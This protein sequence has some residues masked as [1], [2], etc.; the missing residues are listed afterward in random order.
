MII[1]CM[2]IYI[3][4]YVLLHPV[5]IA[6]IHYPRSAPRAG[7][8][9]KEIRTLSARL[10]SKGRVRKDPNLGL[11]T[12]CIVVCLCYVYCV[13]YIV[14]SLL[15]LYV[16]LYICPRRSGLSHYI[17]DHNSIYIYIYT[18]RIS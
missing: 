18:V 16:L 11:R 15:L 3:Y 8:G 2:Y 6:R 12:G 9:F 10:I 4:I 1:M 17:I 14:D 5:R 13:L 7:L